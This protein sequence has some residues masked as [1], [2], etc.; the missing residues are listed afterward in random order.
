M[1]DFSGRETS[2]SLLHLICFCF[3]AT[4]DSIVYSIMPFPNSHKMFILF[5]FRTLNLALSL[6][7]SLV[8]AS[9]PSNVSCRFVIHELCFVWISLYFSLMLT[10][11]LAF[12]TTIENAEMTFYYI[13][14]NCWHIVTD[15]LHIFYALIHQ[16][17][18]AQRLPH[19]CGTF[20][21]NVLPRCEQTHID[22]GIA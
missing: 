2:A 22:A 16:F 1:S 15:M 14:R 21:M 8:A 18:T 4:D 6:F 9:V 10:L 13:E 3:P 12:C 7:L 5:Y 17:S 11:V 20:E 19:N